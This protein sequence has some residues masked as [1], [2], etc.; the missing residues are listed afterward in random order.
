MSTQTEVGNPTGNLQTILV[1]DGDD[2]ARSSTSKVLEDEGHLCD[3][4]GSAAAALSVAESKDVSVLVA[5]TNIEGNAQLELAHLLRIRQP[6]LSI[7]ITTDHPTVETAAAAA[8]LHAAAYLIK[9]VDRGHLIR[10]IREECEQA[11]LLRTLTQQRIRHEGILDQMR[12]LEA[13][14][15]TLTVPLTIRSCVELSFG[16]AL[17]S[18][19]GLKTILDALSQQK[20]AA[21][22]MKSAQ[23]PLLVNAIWETINVLEHTRASFK[24]KELGALRQ[25]LEG[26][27]PPF[28]GS[29]QN[30]QHSAKTVS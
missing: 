10:V 27:V 11:A 14:A 22:M 29:P 16:Q 12:A 6:G 3:Q 1:A 2:A 15:S 18:L 8:S 26:L 30:Q 19:L 13:H 9:P 24:S 21:E 20:H 17:E 5:D 23:P 7:V 25:K 4:V 28:R